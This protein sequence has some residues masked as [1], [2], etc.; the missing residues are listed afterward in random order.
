MGF[1]RVYPFRLI[2]SQ[3]RFA[4]RIPL[5]IT[6][7]AIVWIYWCS[8]NAAREYKTRKSFDK[9]A[10]PGPAD[11]FLGRKELEI[12]L[13]SILQPP[14]TCSDYDLVVG[15]QGTGKSTLVCKVANE[16]KG[17]IYVHIPGEI[18]KVDKAFADALNFSLSVDGSRAE[19]IV[20]GLT[21]LE[22]PKQSER[23]GSKFLE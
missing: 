5:A 2:N 22:Q 20:T 9:G 17:I 1:C 7:I 21:K 12:E 11:F 3:L 14:L 15:R 18:E 16:C 8:K 19:A 4:R 23:P 6:S 13:K 10:V